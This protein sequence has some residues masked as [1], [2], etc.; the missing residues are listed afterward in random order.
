MNEGAG[1]YGRSPFL[2][3]FSRSRIAS[4]EEWILARPTDLLNEG[5][6]LRSRRSISVCWG[7]ACGIGENRSGQKW[8]SNQ[9]PCRFTQI[10]LID[11]P[12]FSAQLI[13]MVEGLLVYDP[14]LSSVP[15]LGAQSF[16]SRSEYYHTC[17]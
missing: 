12:E 16:L 8:G 10:P 17:D 9:R 15:F 3:G 7:H 14:I 5:K 11:T 13:D 6:E 4:D 2:W 1:T